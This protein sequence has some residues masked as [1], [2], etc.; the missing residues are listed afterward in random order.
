MEYILNSIIFLR[1]YKDKTML[2]YGGAPAKNVLTGIGTGVNCKFWD[3]KDPQI[4]VDSIR[5]ISDL[6]A[7]GTSAPPPKEKKLWVKL[8]SQDNP[9]M[10][11]I[12]L[13]LTMFPG[14]QQMII[15][16][17]KE[18][19]RIGAKCLIH[20]GLILELQEMLGEDKVVVK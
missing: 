10:K 2:I 14:E 5:P 20:E 12:E 18:Q 16:C 11:R 1:Y 3:E 7:V 17:E 6:N 4:M 19:K 15:Y 13:I 8:D 9:A